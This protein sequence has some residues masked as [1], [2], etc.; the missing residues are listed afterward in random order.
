MQF[1]C[2]INVHL[3]K[4]MGFVVL[5]YFAYAGRRHL[6][7]SPVYFRINPKAHQKVE[8]PEIASLDNIQKDQLIRGYVKSITAS[9]ISLG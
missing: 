1:H 4:S 7:H 6:T 3:E 5:I 9:G 8:D 2:I